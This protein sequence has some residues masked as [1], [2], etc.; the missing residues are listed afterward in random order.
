MDIRRFSPSAWAGELSAILTSA[1]FDVL[2]RKERCSVMLTGGRSA[3]QLY[4]TWASFPNF[5]DIQN[6]DFYFSDERFVP[7]DHPESNYAL[8]MN[9]LFE[10]SIPKNSFVHC[11]EFKHSDKESIAQQYAVKLPEQ[12]DILLLSIGEDGHIASLFPQSSAMDE[13]NQLVVPIIGPKAPHERFSITPLVIKNAAKIFV[14][15]CGQEK[16]QPL[17]QVILGSSDIHSLPALIVRHCVW[18]TDSIDNI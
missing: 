6:I 18:I 17:E 15:A 7:L 10:T 14:M 12:I 1:I 2:S 3:A 11:F 8:A 13:A 16:R 4:R 5:Q 9:N